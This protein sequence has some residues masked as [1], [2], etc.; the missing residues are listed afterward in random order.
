[1]SVRRLAVVVT[2]YALVLPATA[3]AS[4]LP[5]L[6]KFGASARWSGEI[7]NAVVVD[8]GTCTTATCKTYEFDIRVSKWSDPGGL[9]VSLRWPTDQLDFGYDLD[10]Y[11][12]GP[13]GDV[14]ARSNTIGYSVAE[15]LWVQR[16]TNGRY[17]I[18]VVPRDVIGSSPFDVYVSL[19]RGWTVPTTASLL[20]TGD[21]AAEVSPYV[22]QL[23]F[24]G[25][26]PLKLQ[27]MLP[28]LVALK[29]RN[30]HIE[31]TVAATF[32]VAS[33]RLP[34]HQP[35]CYPQEITGLTADEPGSQEPVQRCLRWDLALLNTGRGPFEIRAYP[36]SATPTD[37][38]QA[39]YRSDGSY[40][41]AQVGDAKFSSAHGHVHV[42]GMDKAGLYTI[43]KDGSRGR[44]VGTLPEKGFCPLDLI[45]GNFGTAAGGP[46][47][48]VYPSTCDAEDN[49]DP[50]D[51]LYPNEQ[52]FRMGVSSG[53][54]DIY[55]WFIPDQYIDI[56][57]VEDGRY[58]IVYEVN[59]AG[60]VIES[61]RSNNTASA[62][63]EFRG[64]EVKTC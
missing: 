32:Y 20:G 8:S 50:K 63:V 54:V 31:S 15:A 48:Y 9:L 53:W 60:N 59:S 42:R 2:L 36:E 6:S 17:R 1:M 3:N 13:D 44:L 45:D 7:S 27:P 12:Y 43:D 29:P 39:V 64:T 22:S 19:A 56:T 28:D 61:S 52:Y 57:N 23:T 4:A 30:F 26:P 51:P 16:P 25:R 46:S 24:L 21:T 18:V 47:R 49:R 55:P 62:C 40:F 38:F 5:E 58:L 37:A 34:A 33:Q 14:V 11:L 10:L 41:L 35:S